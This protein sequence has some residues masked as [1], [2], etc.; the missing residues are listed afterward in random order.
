MG[1]A[2]EELKQRVVAIATKV[3][4]YQ[5]RVHRFRKKRMFQ[6]Y[7]QRFYRVLKHEGE[8][9]DDDQPDAEE[10]E[11]FWGDIWIIIRIRNG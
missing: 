11:K 9:C 2:S 6:N 10:S 7:Q 4:G 5:E 1:V 8:R 3:R